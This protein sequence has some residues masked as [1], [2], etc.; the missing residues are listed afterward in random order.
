MTKDAQGN[1]LTGAS[2]EA[3]ILFDQAVESFNIYR[4]DPI[5]SG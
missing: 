1:S 5:G 3:A 2:N 4:G